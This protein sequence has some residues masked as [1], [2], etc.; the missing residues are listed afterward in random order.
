[1][2]SRIVD[3]VHIKGASRGARTHWKAGALGMTATRIAV[4][5]LRPIIRA[6]S[7]RIVARAAMLKRRR[8]RGWRDAD[9]ALMNAISER[10]SSFSL[11]ILERYE[12]LTTRTK[13]CYHKLNI[14]S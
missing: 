9:A 1:M 11:I 3:A 13:E 5:M 8:G 2:Y 4:A 6:G 10:R 12:S 7:A 14:H